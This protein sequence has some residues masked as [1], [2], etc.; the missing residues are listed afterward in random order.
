MSDKS[1]DEIC[2]ALLKRLVDG[3]EESKDGGRGRSGRA[4]A[5]VEPCLLQTAVC[6]S[7]DACRFPFLVGAATV[8]YGLPSV[9]AP[10]ILGRPSSSSTA[11]SSSNRA[12]TKAAASSKKSRGKSARKPSKAGIL[13]KKG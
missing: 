4:A 11:S 7:R 2:K 10:I 12:K 6:E 1:I 8:V 13:K 9:C 5:V 3:G